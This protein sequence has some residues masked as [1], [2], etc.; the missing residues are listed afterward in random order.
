[1][2]IHSIFEVLTDSPLIHRIL[3][4]PRILPMLVI[5]IPNTQYHRSVKSISTCPYQVPQE[6]SLFPDN[7]FILYCNKIIADHLHMKITPYKD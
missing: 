6:W 1:M 4:I 2:C 7:V 5:A 3:Q